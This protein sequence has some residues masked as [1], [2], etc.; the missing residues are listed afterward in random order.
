MEKIKII[1]L[2]NSLYVSIW[3]RAL[4]RISDFFNDELHLCSERYD[5]I[6]DSILDFKSKYDD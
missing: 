5:D 2:I 1:K 4:S 3:R 6:N